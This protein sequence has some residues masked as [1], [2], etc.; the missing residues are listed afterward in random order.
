[1]AGLV[2]YLAHAKKRAP[3]T[4]VVALW[5]RS[6]VGR[7]R[8]FDVVLTKLY[9]ANARVRDEPHVLVDGSC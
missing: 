9:D 3:A 6:V 8:D 5:C 4:D 1:M 7:K 2:G